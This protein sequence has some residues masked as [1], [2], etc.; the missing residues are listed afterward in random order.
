MVDRLSALAAVYRAGRFGAAGPSPGLTIAERR[1]LSLVEVAA[2]PAA[3]EAVCAGI[4]AAVGSVPSV[5][6]NAAI[7]SAAALI[8]WIG[9]GQWLV[10]E[11]ERAGRD[12]EDLLRRAVAGSAA[13][14]V[15]VGQGRT[16]L[17]LAGPRVRELLAKGTSI[18][19]HPRAF[20]A[21]RCAQGMLGHV[22]A[23]MHAVDASTVDLY[24]ARSFALTFWEWLTESAAEF[25]YSVGEPVR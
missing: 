12:L 3:I 9:P 6:A 15:D 20:P 7:A 4:A 18:D 16:V 21:G 22:R 5:S 11:P 23:L 10:V 1:P 14:V 17:R 19:L 13:A 2:D 8:L 24:I 25:G